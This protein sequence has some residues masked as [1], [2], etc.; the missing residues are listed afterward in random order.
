MAATIFWSW[1][2]DV[3]PKRNRHFIREAL[4]EAITA[5]VDD[6]SLDDADRPELDHATKNTAGMAEIAATI[7]KKIENSAVFV[8]DLTPIARSENGKAI[9]NPNVLIE[10]GWALK[11]PGW[12]RVIGVLN[13]ADG[14]RPEHLPFDIRGRQTLSYSLGENTNATDKKTAK[15]RLVKELKEAIRLNLQAHIELKAEVTPIAEVRARI[16]EQSIW[17]TAIGKI[18]HYDSLGRDHR[19]TVMLPN[20]P[21]G[22]IRVIPAGWKNGPAPIS[23]VMS[24]KNDAEVKPPAEGGSGG[25][26]GATEE[27]FIR[28]WIT[29]RTDGGEPQSENVAMYFDETGEFWILHG[30]AVVE[31]SNRKFLRVGPLIGGWSAVLRR[32]NRALD[33]LGALKTRRVEVGLTGVRDARWPGDYEAS[34]PPARKDSFAYSEKSADWNGN[35]QMIF[36]GRAYERLRNLFGLPRPTSESLAK[37]LQ[38]FGRW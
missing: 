32:A 8:A 37:I 16:G 3:S 36:L 11:E 15:K 31:S 27:G 21:R 29:G 17:E 6:L 34:S 4:S 22:Y 24:L 9:P 10:L 5:L 35:A 12:E 7:L 19:T 18:T 14:W 28:Y 26:W 2:N 25:D 13:T 30:S 20:G 38:E 33:Q 23:D 1:Q